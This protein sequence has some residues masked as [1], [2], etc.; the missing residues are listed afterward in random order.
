LDS[1]GSGEND[2]RDPRNAKKKKH[3]NAE[4]LELHAAPIEFPLEWNTPMYRLAVDQLAKEKK[5]TLRTAALMRGI[6][7]VK[8]AKHLRGVFP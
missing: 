3:T 6:G 7:C 8:E 5:V 1:F 4:D 2:V